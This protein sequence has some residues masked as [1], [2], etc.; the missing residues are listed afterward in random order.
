MAKYKNIQY[1]VTAYKWAERDNHSY[2]VGIFDKKHD[3]ILSADNETKI[4]G[5]KYS[6]L[7]EQIEKNLIIKDIND[8]PE[9]V[10]IYLSKGQRSNDTLLI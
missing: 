3:A 9:T 5:G 7:V 6:C 4:R 10:S 8:N 1:L 2:F